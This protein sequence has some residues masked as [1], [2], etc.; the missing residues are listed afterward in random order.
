MKPQTSPEPDPALSRDDHHAAGWWRQEVFADDL[1]ARADDTPDAP[2]YVNHR[3]GETVTVTF[4]QLAEWVERLAA[5]LRARRVGRGE[6]VAFQLPNI[7]ET[8]ALWLACGRAGAVAAALPPRLGREQRDLALGAISPALLVG[9]D[10]RLPDRL[11]NGAP[12]G[13][14]VALDELVAEAAVQTRP[15]EPLSPIHAD[16]VC[17]LAF[18]SGRA[19]RP[20][21]VAH[22]F[23]TRY[24]ALRVAMRLVPS[25]TATAAIA[26]LTDT[27]GLMFTTLAPLMTGRPSV[28]RDDDDLQ[29]WLDLLADQRVGCVVSTPSVLDDLVTARTR[30][31]DRLPGLQQVV[32]VGD[33][34][35]PRLAA[36]L[37]TTLAPHL[38]NGFG[39][40]ETGMLT[41]SS[42]AL[43]IAE[44][45][46]GR[47]VEGVQV[48]LRPERNPRAADLGRLEVRSPGL[49]R[50]VIDLRT[51]EQ[52]WCADDGDGWYGTGDLVERDVEGRLRH[53]G[54]ATVETPMG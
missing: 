41:A 23:N 51:R 10:G 19:G 14:P 36:R 48:R 3:R 50:R 40:T 22:T 49:C 39:T 15:V 25:D 38:V 16:K 21:A 7:W 29:G 13:K 9:T 11:E 35:P 24:A 2:A 37:R 30:R 8:A 33:R 17:Q 20:K 52:V 1:A 28:F 43:D 26:D 27:V 45:T 42:P 18:T 6:V 31:Q 54:R 5:A 12:V 53:L 46:L 32:S 47:P 4:A 44:E 34:L